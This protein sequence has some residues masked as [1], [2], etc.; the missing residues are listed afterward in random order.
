MKQAHGQALPL[1]LS[2]RKGGMA[3]NVTGSQAIVP[4][5]RGMFAKR[6]KPAEYEEL[7]RRRTVPEV[8]AVLKRHPYFGDSLA[9]LSSADPHREQVE[10][11][12]GMDIFVKYEQLLHY[13]FQEHSFSEYFIT[14]CEVKEIL[15]ALRLL[16]AGVVGKYIKHMPPFLEGQLQFDLCAVAEADSFEELIEAVRHTPYEKLLRDYWLKDPMLKDYPAAESMLIGYYYG[17]VFSL[18]RQYLTGR[19]EKAVRDLFCKR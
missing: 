18:A 6:I 9:T 15:R 1:G 4:K 8:A 13:E 10:E 3:V 17:Q 7:M 19:E 2:I 11:L 14:E 5:A 16:S 12:L